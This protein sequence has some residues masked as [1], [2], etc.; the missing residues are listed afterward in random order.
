M[1]SQGWPDAHDDRIPHSI[2]DAPPLERDMNHA[3][4]YPI[5]SEH[6]PGHIIRRTPLGFCR[7]SP[8][9]R[10]ESE[11][12]GRRT[13]QA[14]PLAF[15]SFKDGRVRR[16]RRRPGRKDLRVDAPEEKPACVVV[17]GLVSRRAQRDLRRASVGQGRS[18]CPRRQCTRRSSVRHTLHAIPL[19]DLHARQVACAHHHRP[20]LAQKHQSPHSSPRHP[21]AGQSLVR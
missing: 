20:K 12:R 9:P 15:R 18:S 6:A 14:R 17:V 3:T 2:F 16:K 19:Y 5:R 4:T 21:M 1:R 8:Q 13:R 11:L 10:P 7:P